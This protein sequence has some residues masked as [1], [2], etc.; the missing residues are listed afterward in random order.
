M[1]TTRASLVGAE[2]ICYLPVTI[3]S[4][5]AHIEES[6]FLRKDHG[7]D[8]RGAE[9]RKQPRKSTADSALGLP[10]LG[11]NSWADSGRLFLPPG[12]LW[13]VVYCLI[14]AAGLKPLSGH[15][16]HFMSTSCPYK[17]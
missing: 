12:A 9:D 6:L 17:N 1:E 3:V 13:Q 2:D 7:W 11:R 10:G 15:A 16:L 8:A 4:G 5:H 14:S